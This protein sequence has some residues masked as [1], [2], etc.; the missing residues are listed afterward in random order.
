MNIYVANLNYRVQDQEL[1]ELFEEYGQ[2][3][4]A[5]IIKDHESGRS[6]GFA[7][8]E[9]PDDEAGM[10]AI[11]ELDGA[12]VQGRNLKVSKARPRPQMQDRRY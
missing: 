12:E 1:Q 7:F 8:V 4:S 6:R 11:N 3:S 10:Q 9:M 2:V 5:K